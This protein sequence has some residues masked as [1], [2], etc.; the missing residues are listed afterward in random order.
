M[1]TATE[2]PEAITAALELLDHRRERIL[3]LTPHAVACERA[4]QLL[5][6]LQNARCSIGTSV[7]S[8]TGALFFWDANRPSEI[9]QVLQCFSDMGYSLKGQP[10]DYGELGRR[11]W[12]LV[13]NGDHKSPD[14]QITVGAFF[15]IEGGSLLR[16]EGASEGC[17]Y[18]K[19]GERTETAYEFVC[20]DSEIPSN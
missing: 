15:P 18:V 16:D 8:L 20:P 14:P 19:K 10:S 5:P 9:A 6:N 7:H 3:A 13:Q 12:V 4:K 11:T 1:T 2:H 17:R